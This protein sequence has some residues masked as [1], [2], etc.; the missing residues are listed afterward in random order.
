MTHPWTTN[1]SFFCE[2]LRRQEC[3]PCRLNCN[4]YCLDILHEIECNTPAVVK[5]FLANMNNCPLCGVFITPEYRAA[6]CC[7]GFPD[8]G[9]KQLLLLNIPENLFNT[10][11]WLPRQLSKR[12]ESHSPPRCPPSPTPSEIEL[13][14]HKH[15]SPDDGSMKRNA[16]G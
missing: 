16:C 9:R 1:P 11:R 7:D 10:P 6:H 5:Y 13:H 8:L 2:L 3:K 12:P 14:E 4:E 15:D